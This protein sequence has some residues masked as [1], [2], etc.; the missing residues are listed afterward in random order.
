MSFGTHTDDLP[1]NDPDDGSLVEAFISSLPNDINQEEVM[2]A[3]FIRTLSAV[4]IEEALM[5]DEKNITV[6]D[7]YQTPDRDFFQDRH[8]TCPILNL[9][10]DMD[11]LSSEH[12]AFLGR[13]AHYADKAFANL[14]SEQKY[15]MFMDNMHNTIDLYYA[16]NPNQNARS[17][18]F[19]RS[20]RKG[21]ISK[22]VPAIFWLV[23]QDYAVAKQMVRTITLE[24]LVNMQS[25]NGISIEDDV[26]DHDDEI[27][28]LPQKYRRDLLSYILTLPE[29]SVSSE[30]EVSFTE[31]SSECHM[32]VLT[33]LKKITALQIA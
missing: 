28:I 3:N 5:R 20:H 1:L 8:S 25:A 2:I 13:F 15:G 32:S 22:V 14:Q 16:M 23:S 19:W 17:N 31:K 6:L 24:T 27:I 11:I 29:I 9:Y 12:E 30:G 33:G 26:S 10:D 18:T 4:L 7:V 21:Y